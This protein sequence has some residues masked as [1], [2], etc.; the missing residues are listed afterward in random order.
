MLFR[1]LRVDFRCDP[2]QC[3]SHLS[4]ALG[5][6][7]HLCEVPDALTSAFNALNRK[8]AVICVNWMGQTRPDSVP[9]T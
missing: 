5:L 3:T 4:E 9:P 8:I 2:H 7:S 6:Q 1:P